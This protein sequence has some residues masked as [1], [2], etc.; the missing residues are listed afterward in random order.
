ML[1]LQHHCLQISWL[2]QQAP[3]NLV[4]SP[5]SRLR[6]WATTLLRCNLGVCHPS[7]AHVNLERQKPRHPKI[8]QRIWGTRELSLVLSTVPVLL[9]NV[10]DRIEAAR[11]VSTGRGFGS[12]VRRL[13]GSR[14]ESFGFLLSFLRWLFGCSR[15]DT[16]GRWNQLRRDWQVSQLWSWSLKL[17]RKLHKNSRKIHS[18][19]ANWLYLIHYKY[20][21][22]RKILFSNIVPWITPTISNAWYFSFGGLSASHQVYWQWAMS[23]FWCRESMMQKPVWIKFFDIHGAMG[24]E[25]RCYG[26]QYIK[27]WWSTWPFQQVTFVRSQNIL[28]ALLPNWPGSTGR[29]CAKRSNADIADFTNVALHSTKTA[30]TSQKSKVVSPNG[31]EDSGFLARNCQWG[32]TSG[33]FVI[34]LVED[35]S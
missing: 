32:A 12:S 7:V 1:V 4:Y 34:P 23:Y 2:S 11:R 14:W 16:H 9:G 31:R 24:M 25:L 3:N 26:I 22:S 33:P 20:E 13:A 28:P 35:S 19:G 18:L 8:R 21:L 29:I 27:S 17:T 30:G 6:I 15:I 5:Q 10:F